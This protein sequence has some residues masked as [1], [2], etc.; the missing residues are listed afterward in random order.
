M[1]GKGYRLRGI[2]AEAVPNGFWPID[3]GGA[4]GEPVTRGIASKLQWLN[5]DGASAA[6]ATAL[7]AAGLPDVEGVDAVEA[8]TR[9]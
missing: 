9:K 7:K 8:F 5:G 6:A 4:L 1:L 2:S 3:F